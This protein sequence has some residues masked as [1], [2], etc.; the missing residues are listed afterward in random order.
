ML[1][2]KV[3]AVLKGMNFNGL[4]FKCLDDIAVVTSILL[5]NIWNNAHIK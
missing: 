1:T 5:V 3:C 2:D 4:N